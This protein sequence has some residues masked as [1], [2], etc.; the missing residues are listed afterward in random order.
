MS[1]DSFITPARAVALYAGL[2]EAWNRRDAHGFAVLFAL[3]G[4]AIG[5]DGSEMIGR[6]QIGTTLRGI[7][8]SHETAMYVAKVREVRTLGAD[9]LLLRAVV[10][11]MP[12]G[13]TEL[14]PE[15]NAIQSLVIV[16]DDYE[17]QIALLQNTPAALH[18]RPQAVAE[19]TDELR[20]V[21]QSGKLVVE[22]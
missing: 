11:M 21:V 7:F 18:G 9:A 2:L 8:E 3:D 16:E 14:N 17:L 1:E 5:F 15:A 4:S 20:A 13:K 6:P 22:S 10:G 19:L 12:R